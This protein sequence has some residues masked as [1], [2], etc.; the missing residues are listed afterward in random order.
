MRIIKKG[1]TSQSLYFFIQDSTTGAALTGLVYNT[2]GLTADYVL[3]GGS[4]T[5]I[6]LATLA[7]ANSAFSSGGFKEVDA[8]NM[9]GLYRLDPPNAALTGADSVAIT[10]KGG[11]TMAQVCEE[12]QLTTVDFQEATGSVTINAASVTAVWAYVV[13]GSS[14]AVQYMRLYAAALF[15][16]LSG[17]ATTTVTVRDVGDTKNRIIATVDASGNRSAIGTLDGS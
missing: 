13:E 14:T 12:V 4:R 8:T 3:N 10:L 5:N 7:A 1:A 15:A 9:P 2:S 11:S 17:A 6:T 16:K